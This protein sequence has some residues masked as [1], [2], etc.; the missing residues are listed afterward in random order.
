M[1]QRWDLFG[2]GALLGRIRTGA[3]A[4]LPGPVLKLE[5]FGWE[6]WQST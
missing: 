3:L 6:P 5:A 4:D 2:R 1:I